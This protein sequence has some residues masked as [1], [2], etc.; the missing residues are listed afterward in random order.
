MEV[1]SADPLASSSTLLQMHTRVKKYSIQKQKATKKYQGNT[2]ALIIESFFTVNL[3]SGPLTRALL[4][5]FLALLVLE[6]LAS[7][8]FCG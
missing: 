8:D 2:D 7:A 5:A 3:G 6:L 1:T 4:P